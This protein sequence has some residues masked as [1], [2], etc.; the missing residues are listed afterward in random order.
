MYVQPYNQ[1]KN[2]NSIFQHS[3]KKYQGIS[4]PYGDYLEY[5]ILNFGDV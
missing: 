4:G 3:H 5:Q 2:I 1:N